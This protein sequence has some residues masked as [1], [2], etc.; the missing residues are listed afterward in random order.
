MYEE[1]TYF[2]IIT[3]SCKIA[4]AQWQFATANNLDIQILVIRQP[5]SKR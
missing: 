5:D 2:D 1:E 3:N 4:H